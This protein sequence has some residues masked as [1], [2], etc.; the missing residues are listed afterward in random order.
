LWFCLQVWKLTLKILGSVIFSGAFDPTDYA[1]FQA[2]FGMIFTV[3]IAVCTENQNPDVM[4]PATF[5]W[6]VE[7]FV[8]RCIGNLEDRRRPRNRHV[9]NLSQK[10][11]RFGSLAGSL[12]VQLTDGSAHS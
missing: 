3:I 12:P 8:S 10:R 5:R 9:R 7:M 1:G 6:K 2:T 4:V 11:E